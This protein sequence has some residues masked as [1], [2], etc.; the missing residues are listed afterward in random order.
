MPASPFHNLVV[1]SNDPSNSASFIRF[2]ATITG[3]SLKPSLRLSMTSISA[4]CSARPMS[5]VPVT[6]KNNGQA[7][8]TINAVTMKN[9]LLTTDIQ[10]PVTVN[11]GMSKT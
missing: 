5:K 11:A 9:S 6:S 3:E 1:M 10:L 2:N 7:A 4:K 8:M